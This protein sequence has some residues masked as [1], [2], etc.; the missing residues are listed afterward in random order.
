M[1]YFQG[2]KIEPSDI[3]SVGISTQR[4]TFTNWRR[5][6]GKPFHNFIT[7]KDL[8][9]DDLVKEWNNSLTMKVITIASF[10]TFGAK[11]GRS[12]NKAKDKLEK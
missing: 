10:D 2:A 8:R 11:I 3:K 4:A 1:N 7:W 6:N 9:A 5:S 12:I